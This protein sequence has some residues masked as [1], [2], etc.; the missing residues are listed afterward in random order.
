M[1]IIGSQNQDVTN[2]VFYV[3]YYQVSC[4]LKHDFVV[5]TWRLAIVKIS[6]VIVTLINSNTFQKNNFKTILLDFPWI[7]TKTIVKMAM[8]R[9]INDAVTYLTL[10]DFFEGF[11]SN[12]DSL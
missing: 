10:L 12:G 4:P 3:I 5:L 1:P 6:G 8:A 2:F 9:M 11:L 7:Q